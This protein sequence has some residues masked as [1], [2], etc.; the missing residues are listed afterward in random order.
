MPILFL[1][2]TPIGNLEDMTFRAVRV[3]NEVDLVAAE[4]TRRA[5]V[6]F[7][8]YDIR[9]RLTSYHEQG[10]GVKADWL[11]RQLADKDV[12]LITEAGMPSIS[13]PGYGLV[14]AALEQGFAIEVIP[15]PSAV[16]TALAISGLPADQ[17]VFLG[18]LPRI[19]AQRRRF[20][21][22]VAQEERTLVC[23]EA[24]HRICAAL[25]DVEDILG[26]RP[27]A[28]C[29]ELTKL[30]QEVFRGTTKEAVAHFVQPRG[31]FTLVIGGRV[32]SQEPPTAGGDMAARLAVLKRE[33]AG[34]REAV[35]QVAKETGQPKRDVYRLWLSLGQE[36]V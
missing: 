33:G 7:S 25:K 34:A 31:E 19:P 14:R 8:R 18:F 2:G 15:G 6:L 28:V 11:V 21:A 17:F 30:H 10:Q 3:L 26:D 1:V 12:A 23:L 13:D 35:A 9:T 32:K 4:D 22:S 36:D 29:R 20:L 27:I 5:K 24:P 16:T